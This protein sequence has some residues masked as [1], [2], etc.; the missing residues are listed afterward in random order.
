M[1]RG[2]KW[3]KVGEDLFEPQEE[4]IMLKWIVS[5]MAVTALV[6]PVAALADDAAP[7][8]ATVASQIC[9]QLKS[10]MVAGTFA[11]TFGT[12]KS[13]SNA[14]GKCVAKNANIASQDVSNAAKTCKAAQ[15]ADPAG[16]AKLWG[17][18]GKDGSKGAGKNA[19]GKCISGAVK[20]AVTEQVAK[21]K[22]A[23]AQCKAA[24]KSDAKAFA[25]AYG[26]SKGAF[27]KCVHDKSTK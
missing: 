14:F 4:P 21:I 17:S 24:L 18:N 19:L 27:A 20:H 2:K 15:A 13:K 8:P 6:V 26:S 23:G 25:T 16:F 11:S 5:V 1:Q 22:G 3:A 10:T 9:T 7:A 12:N